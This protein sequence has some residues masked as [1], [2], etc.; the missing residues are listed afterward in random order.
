MDPNPNVNMKSLVKKSPKSKK[1]KK[2]EPSD[3]Y[4]N[5]SFSI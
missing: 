3:D 4:A 1:K 5:H 2:E